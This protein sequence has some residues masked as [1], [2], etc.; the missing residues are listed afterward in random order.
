MPRDDGLQMILPTA[1]G[2]LHVSQMIQD[3]CVDA[4]LL[5]SQAVGGCP[6]WPMGDQFMKGKKNMRYFM[7]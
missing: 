6:V 4:A 3:S 5:Q 7:I 1:E 2:W